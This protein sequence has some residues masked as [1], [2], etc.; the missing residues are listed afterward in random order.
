MWEI[1][2]NRLHDVSSSIFLKWKWSGWMLWSKTSLDFFHKHEIKHLTLRKSHNSLF[3]LMFP[4]F[5]LVRLFYQ[6]LQWSPIRL[7]VHKAL[8]RRLKPQGWSLHQ[9]PHTYSTD[10]LHSTSYTNTNVETTWR[11]GNL[12]TLQCILWKYKNINNAFVQNIDIIN[13]S[14]FKCAN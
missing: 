11:L 4:L 8:T 2:A 14:P 5:K 3:G 1:K 12:F 10:K 9:T 13:E 7:L 6:Y